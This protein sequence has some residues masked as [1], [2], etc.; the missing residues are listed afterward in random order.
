MC[1]ENVTVS[2]RDFM[3]FDGVPIFGNDLGLEMVKTDVKSVRNVSKSVS[4]VNLRLSAWNLHSI[5]EIHP[6]FAQNSSIRLCR[7]LCRRRRF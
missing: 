1:L 2:R 7:S 4:R 6:L 3:D 5:S